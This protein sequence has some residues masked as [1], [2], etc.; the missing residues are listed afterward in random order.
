MGQVPV[1]GTI[2]VCSI[3]PGACSVTLYAAATGV[4]A[5]PSSAVTTTSGLSVSTAPVTFRCWP[6]S[7]GATLYGTVGTAA[8][9]VLVS[10]VVS[11]AR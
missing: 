11:S 5:G 9:T 1:S 4:Y 3:P 8:S 10:Y 2:A 7:Q 6:S